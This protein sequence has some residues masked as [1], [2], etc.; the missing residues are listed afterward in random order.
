MP[1]EKELRSIVHQ[2]LIDV[3][4]RPLPRY[5]STLYEMESGGDCVTELSSVSQT[6][7]FF[8]DHFLTDLLSEN[9][10]RCGDSSGGG[11]RSSSSATI[12]YEE[13]GNSDVVFYSRL[14]NTRLWYQW[15]S[16]D[17]SEL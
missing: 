6:R 2:H 5:T 7:S 12:E 1:D 4:R 17:D 8:V 13:C 9:C 14:F 3:F 16:L 15:L 10:G 11:G